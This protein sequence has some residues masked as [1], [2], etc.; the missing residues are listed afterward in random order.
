MNTVALGWDRTLI[1]LK[2]YIR[3]KESVFFSFTFPILLLVLF[4]TIFS[5]QFADA[6]PGMSAARF[7]LPGMISAGVLLTSF[8]TMA[9][10]VATERDDGTLKRL[11]STPMPP[12]AYFLG[13]VGLVLITSLAQLAVLLA[14]ARLAYDVAM[15]ADAGRWLEKARQLQPDAMRPLLTLTAIALQAKDNKRALELA[16]AGVAAHP[17]DQQALD[18]L[19]N[20]QLLMGENNQSLATYA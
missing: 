5:G 8:Q 13:K 19:G 12:A 2:Q 6:G 9:M 7:F 1:E 10:S 4:A 14:V 18:N 16:Q 15:P 11:R 3:E 17:D 20:V